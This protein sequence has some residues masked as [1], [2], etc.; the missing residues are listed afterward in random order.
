MRMLWVCDGCGWRT[1]FLSGASCPV[2][3][4]GAPRA[5]VDGDRRA[6]VVAEVPDREDYAFDLPVELLAQEP[7]EARG[8]KRSDARL[9]VLHRSGGRVEHRVF[10]DI[11]EYVGAGDVL[12]VNNAR[13]VPSLLPGVDEGGKAVAVSIHSPQGEGTWHCLVAPQAACRPGARFVLGAGLQVTGQLLDE[14]AAGRWRIALD[15][16]DPATLYA[17]AEPAY[18]PY[19]KQAPADPEYYQNTYASVPGAVG[20]PA[21]GRHF[22]P[23]LLDLL[24]ERGVSVAEVTHFLAA[25]TRR[26]VTRMLRNLIAQG[27]AGDL[28]AEDLV[29][30]TR[31]SD[32]FDFPP[33]ERYRISEHA[34]DLINDRR[35]S[36]GRILVVGTSALRALETVTGPDGRTQPGS[37]STSLRIM[38]GHRF[39]ACDA[40]LTNLHEP[41]S[42]ELI[43]VAALTGRDFLLDT[44]RNELIPRGYRFN[45]FGDSMLIA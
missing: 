30:G 19:L 42:S 36:G 26:E 38:P 23:A 10:T 40:F 35:A 28:A 45:Y 31:L 6:V 25:R 8:G 37:G 24:R 13:F 7:P 17:L 14:T 16:C 34:A 11:V 1:A 5:N 4:T 39:R 43:L 29:D 21:A 15:P 20:N 9:A 3:G 32:E 2:P 22:T 27:G 41:C 18:S 44:Y 12:V 33:A